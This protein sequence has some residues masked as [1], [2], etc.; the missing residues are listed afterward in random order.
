MARA[1]ASSF[2]AEAEVGRAVIALYMAEPFFAHVVHGLSRRIDEA[3]QT[4]AVALTPN[5]IEL[6]ISPTF[7]ATLSKDERVAVV[8]HEVLHV[9]LKHLLRGASR[10][11]LLWNLACDVVVN[12]HIGKWQLPEG[13]I[14][15]NT[16]PDLRLP[17]DGTAEQVYTLLL[18]LRKELEQTKSEGGGSQDGQGSGSEAGEGGEGEPG[19]DGTDP[20]KTSAP[21][22]A[23]ALKRL[24]ASKPGAVGGHSD[25]TSWDGQS[26]VS[27]ASSGVTSAVSCD[28]GS[29]AGP[30]VLAVEA[31][32]DGMLVRAADRTS[33][34]AWGSVPGAVRAAIQEARERG[35]P[36]VDWKRTLRLFASG[37]GRT[38]LVLTSRRESARY[39]NAHLPGHPVDPRDPRSGRLVPGTRIKRL[40][41]L[42]VAVD[43]SGSIGEATIE[44]FFDEID[45]I[46]R[47]GAAVEVVACDAAVHESFAYKGRAPARMGGG[48]GTAFEPVFRWMREQKGRRYDGVIYLTDGCGPAPDTRPPCKLLWVVTDRDGM[49]EHLRFGRQILLEAV[50]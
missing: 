1:R 11:P 14:T 16:F 44:A 23:E 43:T 3:T 30:N 27:E 4:A 2:D 45:A 19:D 33:A 18:D 31:A 28:A 36:R 8:K 48:G 10:E 40:H 46:W 5:G 13:A 29:A 39:G 35:T 26:V 20:S 50:S 49:G 17:V 42:L 38:K 6:R 15:R 25:H 34:S 22:S 12:G 24:G 41:S 21:T 47:S 32:V 9:V 37:T 7:F